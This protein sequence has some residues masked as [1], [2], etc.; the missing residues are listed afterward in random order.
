MILYKKL[1]EAEAL[2]NILFAI[3]VKELPE[4]FDADMTARFTEDGEVEIFVDTDKK[5]DS[6]VN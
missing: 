1:T 6:L 2:E 5:K 3:L 4:D